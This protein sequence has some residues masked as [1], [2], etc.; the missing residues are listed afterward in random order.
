M[1]LETEIVEEFSKDEITVELR[2]IVGGLLN[3]ISTKALPYSFE[4]RLRRGVLEDAVHNYLRYYGNKRIKEQNLLNDL[5]KW[6]NSDDVNWP[7][8]FV[9]ICNVLNLEP[10]YLRR[11]LARYEKKQNAVQKNNSMKYKW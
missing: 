5:K 11:G 1:S 10:D 4:I 3:G 6:F 2:K 9:N 7:Y 8:S